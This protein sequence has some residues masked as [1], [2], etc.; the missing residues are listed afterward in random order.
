M[1]IT[2]DENING[3]PER[4][5]TWENLQEYVLAQLQVKISNLDEDE[6][7][8]E[9]ISKALKAR[10]QLSDDPQYFDNI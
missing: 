2:I 5:S 7:T 9:L 4:F 10:T 8:P 3:L 1:I 6:V